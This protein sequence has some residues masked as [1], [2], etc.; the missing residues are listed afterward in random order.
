LDDMP[1]QTRRLL[2]LLWD[3]VQE[4]AARTKTDVDQVWFTR[5]QVRERTGWSNTQLKVHLDRLLDLE[6]LVLRRA[7]HGQSF[8]YELLYDGVG[9]DGRRFMC[10]LFDVEK[11]RTHSD[12]NPDV[13]GLRAVAA[14]IHGVTGRRRD[15]G[16]ETARKRAVIGGGTAR[17]KE[18]FLL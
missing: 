1:P 18:R 2:E 10:G 5:R 17:G 12:R 11:L 15:V 9:Q 3:M 16:A 6:Y 8:V 14:T 13:S 7:D 4:V